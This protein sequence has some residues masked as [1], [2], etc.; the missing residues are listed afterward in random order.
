MDGICQGEGMSGV[1]VEKL[2]CSACNS[3]D[4]NQVFEEEGKYT[5]YCFSCG[6]YSEDPYKDKPKGYKP[7][8]LKK[9]PEDVARELYEIS[10]YPIVAIPERCLTKATLTHFGVRVG[11]SQTDGETPDILY[12]PY[13]KGGEFKAYK[14]KTLAYKAIWSHGNQRDVDP[15]GW[16]IALSS[17]NTKLIITEGE[18]DAM[19][20]YQMIKDKNKNTQYEH[21]IPAVISVPHGASG[22]V[23]D[24][25]KHIHTIDNTFKEVILAFDMDEVGQ[26]WAEE[27]VKNVLPTASIAKLPSKDANACLVEGRS[28]ACVS[29]V[30]WN[31]SQP[32]NTRIIRGSSLKDKARQK[33]EWGMPWPWP[34]LT[35]LTRGRRRGETIYI[36]AGVKMGKSEVVNA[37][38]KQI[39]VDDNLP[40]LLIKPEESVTKTYQMLV[41]KAAGRIFHDPKIPFDEKAFDETEPLIGDKALI[42]D[43]YQFVDWDTLKNDIKYAVTIDG[44]KDVIIDPITAFTN[45]MS[46]A[47]ANEFLI[48]MAAEISAMS[49]DFDFTTYLFCHL[50]APLTGDPHERGGAVLSHQFAGSRGMMRS[51][52]YM[53]GLQGNKNPELTKE[54]RNCRSLVVLEDR[55]FGSSGVV[56]LYWDD[57]TGLFSEL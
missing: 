22:S 54:E 18:E 50:K 3:S 29:A 31:S 17:G 56:N 49:K 6:V 8:F 52:N 9:S 34:K 57:R 36:G 51:C 19:A 26:R 11:L 16:D 38:A 10:N 46:S 32:K 13:T 2:S 15:F 7:T 47:E 23:K 40:C 5:S 25:T 53:I 42:L 4:A 43:S 30:L 48:G 1:C 55:E 37:L 12:R 45:Q 20:L 44:V 33:P 41:G 28:K 24:L 21:L 35:E 39:I 14:A 27:V